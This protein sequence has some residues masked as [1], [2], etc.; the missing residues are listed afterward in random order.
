M[1]R[2][3]SGIALFCAALCLAN[4]GCR[5]PSKHTTPESPA[6]TSPQ[7]IVATGWRHCPDRNGGR[8]G[9]VDA[10]LQL[11]ISQE[12]PTIISAFRKVTG[13]Q[14]LVLPAATSSM[15]RAVLA[16]DA[17]VPLVFAFIGHG[18]LDETTQSSMLCFHDKG[19][20]VDD[21]LATTH[22]ARPHAI[23]ILDACQ[24]ANVDVRKSPSPVSVISASPNE[25]RA[26]RD[27]K[28]ALG[29]ILVPALEQADRNH[30]GV[31]TDRELL[32]ALVRMIGTATVGLP[33]P[34][35]RRQSWV[36]LPI[37]ERA[38]D[39]VG[40]P[41]DI[42]QLLSPWAG[43]ARPVAERERAIR[44]AKTG[45]LAYSPSTIWYVEGE[46]G[47]IPWPEDVLTTR[48]RSLAMALAD[49]LMA[50]RVLHVLSVPPYI[51]V[52]ELPQDE[53]VGRFPTSE[54]AAAV[55]NIEAGHAAWLSDDDRPVA[56][57]PGWLGKEAPVT[58]ALGEALPADRLVPLP[59]PA[60]G[61]TRQCFAVAGMRSGGVK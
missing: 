57:H 27:G 18:F 32:R 25:V 46:P 60:M 49:R 59:C 13:T 20:K 17:S 54:T 38:S 35:L 16:Q 37:G 61:S 42:E 45:S 48:D 39:Q 34:M 6:V 23:W 41:S 44:N 52:Y 3:T 36:D 55:R 51:H 10:P 22:H 50:T 43:P 9:E 12:L 4:N 58:T 15:V 2:Q 24:S 31:V 40:A 28:T 56:F 33:R 7:V 30:D 47:V 21:L 11:T 14:P 19:E 29:E 8:S 1:K 53:F 26:A 5:L